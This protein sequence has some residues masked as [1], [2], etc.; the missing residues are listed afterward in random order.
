VA[1][2]LNG[3]VR[4]EQGACFRGLAGR[5]FHWTLLQE[6]ERDTFFKVM[7]D[8]FDGHRPL[9]MNSSFERRVG[10]IRSRMERI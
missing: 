8:K 4:N 1:I 5:L 6:R 2:K 10:I 7:E 3:L 9:C